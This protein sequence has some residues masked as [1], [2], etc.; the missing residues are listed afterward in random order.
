[1]TVIATSKN[2]NTVL[3]EFYKY[4]INH[5]LLYREQQDYYKQ[6]VHCIHLLCN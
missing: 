6:V 4:A 2:G 3:L 1:M 5:Q